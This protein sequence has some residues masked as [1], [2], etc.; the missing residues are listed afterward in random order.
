MIQKWYD[1]SSVGE[2]ARRTFSFFNLGILIFTLAFGVSEFRFDWCEKL[3]GT[4]L[5]ATNDFRPE[6]GALWTLGQK[7][8]NAH[9]S[10]NK[11]L[12]QRENSKRSV[13]EADSF[14]SL[15]ESLGPGEW[16]TLAK[17]QFKRLYLSLSPGIGRQLI[18]PSH[19]VWLLSANITNRIFCGGMPEGI[20]LYFID[21]QNQVV[22]QIDLKKKTIL[23][24]ESGNTAV[25]GRL[26]QMDGFSSRI[27]PSEQ[28]FNAMVKLP[29]EMISELMVDPELLL[30][31]EGAILRVGIWNEAD[32]GYIKLGFE[33]EYRGEA[34][35][36]IIQAR[37]WAVWQL[38]LLLKGQTP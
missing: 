38:S 17:E 24:I 21:S 22:R 3:L 4:Y 2:W 33:F 34:S 1:P 12:T 8:S 29:P 18:D 13:R 9:H 36:L 35:V 7:T 25:P 31:Q 32:H 10:L 14:S 19:L 16:V 26:G 5:L 11:I 6:T 37:E 30:K 27:Y 20:S 28:F 23:A 15:V